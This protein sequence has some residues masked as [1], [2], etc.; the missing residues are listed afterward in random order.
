MFGRKSKDSKSQ[1][2]LEFE[3]PLRELQKNLDELIER[4]KDAKVGISCEIHALE[5]KIASEERNIFANLSTW[6][7][8]LIARHP[9]RPYARDYIDHI[10]SD[11]Q[12]LHGDRLF[13]DDRA[14]IGG[15]ATLN[16]ESVMVIGEQKGRS[17]NENIECNF[18]CPYPEGYRK[19]LRLMKLAEKFSL[20]IITFVDTPGAY[21]GIGSEERHIAEA[22]A[23]NLR[24]MGRLETAIISIVIGE[25]GS[26]GALGIAMAD[27]V[28]VLENAYY[29]VISPEGCAAI[30]WKDRK[31]A[32]EAAEALQLSPENLLKLGI[33]E[34]ILP[35]PLGGAH[36][37]PDAVFASIKEAI[38]RHL[39]VL[40]KFSP[41]QLLEKRYT[42]FRNIGIFS[43]EKQS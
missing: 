42:R 32:P 22:I 18:G 29:S 4:S 2:I 1:Y 7:R 30:L 24:D 43:E 13:N 27:R 28:L 3:K 35:E 21:P 36:R 38:L 12:E 15:F 34:E 17:L 31:F 26:G 11:F 14:I 20:P 40:K 10:F 9:D 41:K 5:Q 25:G 16:G 37:N 33:V 6:Q 39:K 23:V 8:V 19:A